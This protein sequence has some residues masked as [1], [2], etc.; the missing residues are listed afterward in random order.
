MTSVATA[1]AT[2]VTTTMATVTTAPVSAVAAS[3]PVATI[4]A[5]AVATAAMR[6]VVAIVTGMPSR[7]IVAVTVHGEVEMA[8]AIV[9]AVTPR[10]LTVAPRNIQSAVVP[11]EPERVVHQWAGVRHFDQ[12]GGERI[13]EVV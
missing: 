6:V 11:V 10:N 13:P 9:E 4:V 8:V 7:T 12:V 1:M 3:V 2:T 5:A